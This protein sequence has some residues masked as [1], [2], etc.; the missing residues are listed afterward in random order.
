MLRFMEFILVF[1]PA[2]LWRDFAVTFTIFKKFA[3]FFAIFLRFSAVFI[4]LATPLL[5]GLKPDF[6]PLQCAQ[7]TQLLTQRPKR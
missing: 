5:A 6:H 2:I 3:V 1:R 4:F 7:R